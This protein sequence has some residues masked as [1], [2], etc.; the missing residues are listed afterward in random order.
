MRFINDEGRKELQK[1]FDDLESTLKLEA[2]VVTL[3][4]VILELV[5]NAVKANL[6]RVFFREN[7]FRFDEPESYRAGVDAFKADY[8]NIRKDKYTQAL[9]DLNL[10]VTVEVDLNNDRLLTYVENN[11]VMVFEEEKRVRKKL[12]DAMKSPELLDFYMNYG[13][14]MEGGGIGLAMIIFLIKQMGFD[15]GHFRVFH[16]SEK[17]IARLEFPLKADYVPIRSRY[18]KALNG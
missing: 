9:E 1:F 6:K 15:P 16:R 13:D 17:T 2:L 12:A 14:E 18:E 8:E 10:T 7:N 5:G 11:T 3:F 4:T